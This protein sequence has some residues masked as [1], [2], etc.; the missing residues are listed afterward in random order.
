MK[1]S[2]RLIPGVALFM[3]ATTATHRPAMAAEPLQCVPYARALS[4]V[5]IF[6]DAWT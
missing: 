3:L 6:G 2:S 1:I 4:G 5:E